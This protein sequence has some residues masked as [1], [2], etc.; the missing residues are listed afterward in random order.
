MNFYSFSQ[1]FPDRSLNHNGPGY[2]G[3]DTGIYRPLGPAGE[4]HLRWDIDADESRPWDNR[5]EKGS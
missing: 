3:D 4:G 1:A 2:S 5:R